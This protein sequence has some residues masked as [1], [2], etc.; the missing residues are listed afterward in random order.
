MK[1]LI[2]SA[3]ILDQACKY[4][5]NRNI[6]VGESRKSL[7][8]KMNITNIKNE[9]MAFGVLSDKRL[10]LCVFSIFGLIGIFYEYRRARGFEKLGAALMAGGGISNVYDRLVKGEVTDY[11]YFESNRSSP[12]F[13]LADVFVLMGCVISMAARRVVDRK[14]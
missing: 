11:M 6:R 3:F 10:M 1:K 14:H 13:N 8:P 4:W 7:I 12:V 9:G 2:L 5:V